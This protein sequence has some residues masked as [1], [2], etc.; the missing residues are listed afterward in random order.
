MQLPYS[1]IFIIIL[2]TV[3]NKTINVRHFASPTIIYLKLVKKKIQLALNKRSMRCD[4]VILIASFSKRAQCLIETV[5][6]VH[7]TS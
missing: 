2:L 7:Q 5:T 1:D 6:A 3:K 4:E